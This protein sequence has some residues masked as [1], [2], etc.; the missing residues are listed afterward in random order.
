MI[1]IVYVAGPYR[2]P[3]AVD[4]DYHVA[5]ARMVG[6]LVVAAG[7]CPLIPHA[8][9]AHFDD[10]APASWWL[11]ATMELLRRCDAIVVCPGWERSSGTQAEIV[12]AERRGLP[13]FWASWD[14]SLLSGDL[15]AWVL[16]FREAHVHERIR[17][18]L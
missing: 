5:R 9:T 8:N 13:L 11:T 10:L 4:I 16:H 17:G 2:G 6:A 18:A 3:R 7:A 15:S 14:M 1:P 12:E